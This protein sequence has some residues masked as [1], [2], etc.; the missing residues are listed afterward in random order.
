MTVL[1][2]SGKCIGC[3]ACVVECPEEALDLID[4]IVAVDPAKCK[5][6]GSCVAV[7]PSNA[8]SLNQPAKAVDHRDEVPPEGGMKIEFN[9]N[10]P[11]P[12]SV[13]DYA[14]DNPRKLVKDPD[15]PDEA[16]AW[17]GVWI[18]IEYNRGEIAPVSWEL[19]GEGRKLADTLG[20]ELA[21]V[22]CGTRS[23]RLSLKPLPMVRIRY[24]SSKTGAERLSNGTY[25]AGIT[26]LVQNIN[27]NHA[28]G[29]TA[30]GR[31][32]FRR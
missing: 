13:Q 20:S 4:G 7:C 31:D 21:G 10:E 30:V 22:L 26:K 1:I 16:N 32:V 15:V 3:G 11:L 19:M 6:N 8:L 24:M 12:E 2:D 27:E 28:Y 18:V 23:I 29:A 17:S 5:D 9:Q 25:A 14:Q